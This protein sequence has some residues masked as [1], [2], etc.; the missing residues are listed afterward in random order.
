MCPVWQLLC[1]EAASAIGQGEEAAADASLPL[2]EVM[3]KRDSVNYSILSGGTL[4]LQIGTNDKLSFSS[5]LKTIYYFYFTSY[6]NA[7]PLS[8]GGS[9]SVV[10]EPVT[11]ASPGRL[12]AKQVLWLHPRP[13]ESEAEGR[14]QKSVL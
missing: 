11:S 3:Y 6:L 13:A 12:L 14:A 9:Q 8:P 2:R 1:D 10:P 4:P 5:H 7:E